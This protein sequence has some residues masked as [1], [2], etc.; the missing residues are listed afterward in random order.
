MNLLDLPPELRLHIYDLAFPPQYQRV[1][2][3]PYDA[4]SPAC[5]LDLPLA[6][7][8]VCKQITRELP[9]LRA[10]LRSLDIVY[11][12]GGIPIAHA[13]E[14]RRCDDND[15]ND[16]DSEV[17]RLAKAM[18]HDS[19][20]HH[21]LEPSGTE[22]GRRL[23]LAEVGGPDLEVQCSLSL[24]DEERVATMGPHAATVVD[25][26]VITVFPRMVTILLAWQVRIRLKRLSEWERP[27][28]KIEEMVKWLHRY[29]MR[30]RR[31]MPLLGCRGYPSLL[32]S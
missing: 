24:W 15:D 12:V 29:K 1:Q 22:W 27:A 20:Q 26:V 21:T 16:S 13:P 17:L 9:P 18:R 31:T 14:L 7:Y 10:R 25:R 11:T 23:D 19:K 32:T 4:A 28:E 6:L 5:W 3:L 30:D 8:R 2:L